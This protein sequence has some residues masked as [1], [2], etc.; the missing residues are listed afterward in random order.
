MGED[1]RSC[2]ESAGA[3]QAVDEEDWAE[4]EVGT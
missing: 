2:S 3:G 4:R 1:V